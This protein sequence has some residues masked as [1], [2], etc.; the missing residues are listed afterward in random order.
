MRRNASYGNAHIIEPFAA[1]VQNSLHYA[2]CARKRSFSRVFVVMSIFLV[3]CFAIFVVDMMLTFFSATALRLVYAKSC[4][5]PSLA[6]LR[7]EVQ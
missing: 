7:P 1:I 3:V 5:P 2:G 6:V 4:L